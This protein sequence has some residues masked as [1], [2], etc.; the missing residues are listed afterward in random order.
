MQIPFKDLFVFSAVL[1]A[2]CFIVFL[3][4]AKSNKVKSNNLL[5]LYIAAIGLLEFESLITRL[6]FDLLAYILL[7]VYIGVVFL[8]APLQYLYFTSFAL[9]NKKIRMFRHFVPAISAA[10]IV[11]TFAISGRI[12][13][14]DELKGLVIKLI[15][16][17]L[18][19]AFCIQNIYYI[20]KM[21]KLIKQH[22]RNVTA[23]F[24][25][26]E[27]ISLNWLKMFFL[28]YIALI[29]GIVLIEIIK[30]YVSYVIFD[31]LMILYICYGG[32]W[33]F[34]QNT[35]YPKEVIIDDAEKEK[36]KTPK[37]NTPN[38]ASS[39][40]KNDAQI[41]EI[42]QKILAYIE[43]EKPFLDS[44]FNMFD[45]SRAL[46]INYKYISQVINEEF[47]KSFII[48][49]NERRVEEA[50][51][52]LLEDKYKSLSVEEIAIQAGFQT[53]STF[54]VNF[55]K[56]TSTTPSQYRLRPSQ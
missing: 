8:L 35:I 18:S 31:S 37:E 12:F 13:Y 19:I 50:K 51:K 17:G 14:Y 38:Y 27:K 45:F 41:A 39:S 1:I 32:Y 5:S 22:A 16:L 3:Q 30:D 55:K 10:L 53:P 4:I 29:A 48:F 52:L 33:G 47:G 46:G 9:Q 43:K 20:F 11:A 25:Y 26:K 24:S 44:K 54:Y 21:F 15:V 56:Y 7:P 34:K 2:I 36:R 6:N 23:F 49:I 40:L 42:K 28:G